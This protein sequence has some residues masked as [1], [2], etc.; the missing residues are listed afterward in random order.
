MD[1]K[2]QRQHTH[3]IMGK[4][5]LPTYEEVIACMLHTNASILDERNGADGGA[6]CIHVLE[7]ERA[8]RKEPGSDGLQIF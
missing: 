7:G 1:A 2:N 6:I 4:I 8:E 5:L 3:R